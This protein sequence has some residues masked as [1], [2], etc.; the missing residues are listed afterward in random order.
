MNKI[1]PTHEV[2]FELVEGWIA[3]TERL[4][5]LLPED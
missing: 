4:N 5:S 2:V 3:A 1:R